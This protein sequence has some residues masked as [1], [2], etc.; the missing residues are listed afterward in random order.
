M[1]IPA[2]QLGA[3]FLRI[4]GTVVFDPRSET[5]WLEGH[6]KEQKSGS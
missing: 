5:V 6:A 2:A 3:S 4:F 1:A